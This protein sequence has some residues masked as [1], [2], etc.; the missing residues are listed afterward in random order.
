MTHYIF[1][2][3]LFSIPVIVVSSI[4]AFMFIHFAPGDPVRLMLGVNYDP[5]IA[6]RISKE[7]GLDKP[8][9]AQYLIWAGKALQGDLG[10]SFL[11]KSPVSELFLERLPTTG[12]LAVAS[13]IVGLIIGIPAGVI[14]ATRKNT[15]FDT[16]S[17]IVA[18]IGV[19]M[20]VFWIGILL[21]IYLALRVKFFP[22][23]GGIQEYGLRAMI[24]PSFALGITM[25][26]IVMRITRSSL[27]EELHADYVHTA[28]AK[29]LRESI[30]IWKHAMKNAISPV[31]TIVGFQL[32]YLLGGAVLTESVFNLPGLGR[33]FV[34]SIHGRDYPVVQ[35]CLLLFVVIFV[36]MNLLVDLCYALVDPRIAYD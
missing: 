35:A 25:S 23:G 11:L 21:L 36:L 22:A 32:G 6:A 9:I 34:D 29:G 33:L 2:R 10:R 1:R 28:R 19:S 26:A 31:I 4:L 13:I 3:L 20:P 24:L 30:V 27:L 7:L 12:I 18:M 17:R 15:I 8:F 14:S 16:L 5:E